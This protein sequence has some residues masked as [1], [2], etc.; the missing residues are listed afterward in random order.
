M[1]FVFNS[2]SFKITEAAIHKGKIDAASMWIT[3]FG[4]IVV[5][6]FYLAYKHCKTF[7][8]NVHAILVLKERWSKLYIYYIY[9]DKFNLI[10]SDNMRG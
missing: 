1:Q 5:F 6:W 7:P 3:Y 10:Y 9:R 8:L 2:M 4:K